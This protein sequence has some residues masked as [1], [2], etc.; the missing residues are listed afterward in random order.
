MSGRRGCCI[1]GCTNNYNNISKWKGQICTIHKVNHGTGR[2]VCLPPFILITFP[3]K[4]VE[5]RKEWV[6]RVNRKGWQPN[7]DSWICS[8]HFVNYDMYGMKPDPKYP[9][10]MLQMGYQLTPEQIREKRKPPKGRSSPPIKR[11]KC[12][13][14]T[15][16]MSKCEVQTQD[17]SQQE[18]AANVTLN[19]YVTKMDTEEEHCDNENLLCDEQCD[20]SIAK[21]KN[22]GILRKKIRHLQSK[23]A[24][25]RRIYSKK[26]HKPIGLDIM[27]NDSKVKCY[28]GLPSKEVFGGLFGSFGVKVKKIPYWCG[29]SKIVT[30][31]HLRRKCNFGPQK[32][33]TAKEEFFITLFRTRMMLKAEIIGDLFGVSSTVISRTCLTWWRFLAKE[34][35]ALVYNPCE[36][37][38]QALLPQS[39]DTPLYQNVRHIAGC[40]E[41]FTETPK[42]K[43]I[44]AA[45]WSN[46]KHHHT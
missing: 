32:F 21:C 33:L 17:F 29:P 44:Q 3:T 23:L 25:Y 30:K 24:H 10:P 38:H 2:C 11:S 42:N 26:Q 41:I 36:I 40:T 31:Q 16:I 18:F 8:I 20:M 12:V 15:D 43:V 6:K 14:L 27:K 9:Y 37:A 19:H 5:T 22:C 45:L 34:L 13:D 28:T 7:E 4:D 1:V 35:K 46:Y 39:F